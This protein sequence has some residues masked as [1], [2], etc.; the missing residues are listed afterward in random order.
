MII[1]QFQ[2]IT[3]KFPKLK[4]AQSLPR[5]TRNTR[6]GQKIPSD[7]NPILLELTLTTRNAQSHRDAPS[8]TDHFSLPP[9]LLFHS[10]RLQ[11]K[12]NTNHLKLFTGALE[13]RSNK[14]T[15]DIKTL[16]T[17]VQQKQTDKATFA[18]EANT[19]IIS[20]LQHAAETT[21]GRVSPP[22]PN[23]NKD[24]K[25]QEEQDEKDKQPTSYSSA[26]PEVKLLQTQAQQAI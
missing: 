14:I 7:H 8:P 21:L 12:G 6:S 24:Q 17:K 9:C 13:A 5:N 2:L 23:Q 18:N 19:L 22:K 25:E 15:K 26:H 3:F 1:T 10:S 11:L 16:K 4:G 20:A